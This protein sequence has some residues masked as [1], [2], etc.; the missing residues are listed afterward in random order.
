MF[1]R[2]IENVQ[3][4]GGKNIVNPLLLLLVSFV[5]VVIAFVNIEVDYSRFWARE[6]LFVFSGWV[7]LYFITTYKHFKTIYLFST[8]YIL[9]LCVFHF[10]MIIPD[11][12]GL[13][14][15]YRLE[16]VGFTFWLAKAS[17]YTNMSLGSFSN[18]LKIY[19]IFI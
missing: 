17:W 19:L 1:E 13:S 9:C 18:E 5:V 3:P 15:G 4:V 11:A 16:G 14:S 6:V 2:Q 7:V 10:G 12:L 8:I